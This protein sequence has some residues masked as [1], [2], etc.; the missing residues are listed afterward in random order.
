MDTLLR[1]ERDVGRTTVARLSSRDAEARLGSYRLYVLGIGTEYSTEYDPLRLH[2]DRL[3]RNRARPRQ[4]RRREPRHGE[5]GAA[6]S[7]AV[8]GSRVDVGGGGDEGRPVGRRSRRRL[9][10][11]APIELDP[12]TDS[13]RR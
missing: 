11:G 1:G 9:R 7:D 10:K 13:D 2:K 5:L 8:G 12:S 4:A 6:R 3:S